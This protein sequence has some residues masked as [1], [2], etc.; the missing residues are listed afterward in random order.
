M[1]LGD[2]KPVLFSA[3]V[4]LC[5]NDG[6][7]FF[8]FQSHDDDDEWIFDPIIDE[9]LEDYEASK[10][11]HEEAFSDE[12]EDIQYGGGVA[13]SPL[14]EF[15]L[16]PVGARRNWRNV[17]NRQRFEATL[18]QRRDIAPT[19]NLG[20][21]LTRALQ[22]SIEQQIASDTTLTP[23][24][25]VH[26]TMQSSTFS[27]AFQS[28]TFTVR[29]FKEGSE[30]L[31]M[32]LQSLAQKLNSNEEF[33]PDDT[34][35]METT[36]IRTPGPGSGHGKR[37]KPS[38]AAVRGIVKKSRVTI[39][40]KDNLCCARAVV[41]MKALVDANGDTRDRDYKNLKDGYPIQE[42]KAQELHRLAGVPEGPCGL[43]ELGQ[44]QTALPGYQIK[45]MSIDP[46]HMIIYQGPTPSDKI[47]RL[48]KEGEHYDGCNSFA[49]FLSKSYFCDEC[50]RG[51]D[52]DDFRQHPCH[53]KWCPSCKRKDCPDFLEAKQPLARGQF[54][55]PTSL[56]SLCHRKFF[57]DHC[58][59]YHL[60]RRS[61]HIKSICDSF[62]KC[63]DCCH[64]YEPDPRVVPGRNH[65]FEHRCGYGECHICEKKVHLATHQCYIQ[66]LKQDVDDPKTK[67][68]S[69]NE[70]GSRPFTE[71]APDDPDT[72]VLV[73]R[74]PPLQVYC[75]YEAI[76]DAE[77]N[78]TPILLCAETDE[79]DETFTFY[80]SECTSLFF[81]W[82]EEQA[83]DQDGDDRPVIALF[84]NLKGYDGMF[85]LQHCYATHREVV[86]QI[87]VGTKIL[88]LRT[89]RL[90]FKDS[91]CFLPFPLANFPATFGIEELCKGFFPHKFNTLENQ[92]YDGPMPDISYYDPDGM[93]AKKKAEFERWYAEKVATHYRF[94]MRREME[95][96]CESDVKLLK[97]GCQKF[98]E[99]FK[100]K[101]E[102]DP[103]EKCVTIASACNRFW[104]KKLVPKNKIASEPPRGW[105][106]SRSNQSVKA[107][108]WLAWQEHQL[109]QQ[110]PATG[111][112][113]RTVRNGGEVRVLDRYLVDGFD[114]CDPTTHR[115][116]VYEFHGCLWHGCPKC[117]PRN[118]DR[119]PICHTDRTLNEVHE[120]TLK[121]QESLRQRGYDTKVIWE[122]EW[123]WEIKTNVELCQFLDTFEIVDPLQPR[124][125]FF[126]G[127]TNA[128]KLHHTA[129]TDEE[130]EYIDVT[131][132]YPW[133]NKTREYP[134]GHP[135]VIVNPDDPG[136]HHYFG[137]AKVDILPPYNLYHPVLPYRHQGKLTFPLCRTCVEEVMSKPLLE[138]SY[139]CQHTPEQRTLRGTWCT[140]E[141][142]K[143]VELGYTLIKIHEVQH[144]PPNQRQ[145]GLFAEYVNTWL[146]IK[147]ESAG[148]PA[149]CNTLADKSRYV[150]QYHQKEGIHLD[151][152]LI[153]KNPGRKATAK[154]MLNSFWGKFGEN[155]HKPTTEVVY[156]A[157][158]LF[159]L[160]SNPFND[161][162][163]VRLS[164]DNALEVVYANLKE[165]QPDNGRVNIFVAA[166]TTCHARLKLYSYLEQLQQRVLYFDTDS[167]IYT[168]RSDQ[169]RIPLGDYLGEMT[170]ELDDGDC[171]TEFTSA[172]P[173]N[174]GYKTRQG[175]V[176]CKVR[177]FTL[178]VRGSQQLNYDVMRQNLIDEI[179]QPL[180]ERRNIDVVNP[181]FF[182]RHP[183]TKH[184][185]VIPR[186]KRYGL[187]FDKRVVDPNTFQSF[188]Y[189]YTQ[190]LHEDM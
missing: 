184:L 44:F 169:P 92:D 97:A 32:Y 91:L 101:A 132:L 70:V 145:V 137:M 3:D 80:G 134:V 78:Q 138:K 37:Y 109:R 166:F 179:T 83:V 135:V 20:E 30:R 164:N 61:L 82:L 25:T 152:N 55:S 77:G 118:R 57:G 98:R 65:R 130:I 167:V 49:G 190:D 6:F 155:L 71:P 170:N 120:S 126:G 8:S 185:R 74:E 2:R 108:K 180:D 35:T 34:F 119:H 177:G 154:L 165:N 36:F 111:D 62:K 46:P 124:N 115:P 182:W 114:P 168:T 81:D 13:T 151:P 84:H 131:S 79:D 175:K 26:F 14:L 93:S 54:P 122:C 187:V 174:Y 106:G 40:N 143:A 99:E 173:K 128:V 58:Y 162:R 10:R 139:H 21:E 156:K 56:C 48:I 59:N 60:Q 50:N 161:I 144:F 142:Q 171:I 158:Q 17:L 147:Q 39:K 181:N 183:A 136:I 89:D 19:D 85:I 95:A 112:R 176:C 45:V 160:V 90:T 12:E 52:H 113:I 22:R 69:R 153:V 18:R 103:M 116:T 149:W 150:N 86:D 1:S 96:Y 53:G 43:S 67:R 110:H 94:V 141:I 146:K 5:N 76:T 16:Q 33:T 105:H 107:L 28:T 38:C 121:K 123:D 66:R 100:Q 87:T 41:T 24:S 159:A 163:Q 23:H 189:G 9:I 75:D 4:W 104:R 29:E 72:R 133:V 47:I 11:T 172:G 178:N 88:S 15:D 148:Y 188:P 63:P 117:F 186:T 42:R 64:V 51:F 27:H 127:R 7:F 68:V 102:F 73:E 125:A 129:A 31:N 140:P 157:H